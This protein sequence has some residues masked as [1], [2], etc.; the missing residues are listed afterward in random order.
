MLKNI[1]LSK[2]TNQKLS[3]TEQERKKILET[4]F[5]EMKLK[6]M[7]KLLEQEYEKGFF[8]FPETSIAISKFN[9]EHYILQKIKSIMNVRIALEQDILIYQKQLIEKKEISDFK[10]F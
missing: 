9:K 3:I 2:S 7:R 6:P 5:E 1:V 4:M 8:L 10:L